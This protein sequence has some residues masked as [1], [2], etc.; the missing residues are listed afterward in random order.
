MWF[1]MVFLVM[2]SEL[3]IF[4]LE[5]LLVISCRILVLWFV[6]GL[7]WFRLMNLLCMCF[8]LDSRCWVMVGWISELLLVMVW[9]VLISC[10]RVMFLSRQFLVLVFN[11]V[12]ISWLLL[13]VVRM[14]VGGNWFNCDS[15]CSV[16]SLDII[17][18]CMF[19]SIMLG[20]ICGIM[21]IVWCL[22]VVLVIILMLLLS[23]SSE[24]IFC[25]IR[26]WLLIRQM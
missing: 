2:F 26:V 14:M 1:L 6:N 23:V 19:M 15:I 25:C 24:W 11:L 13:N 5:N 20:C 12:S 16:F 7:G 3:V 21:F 9:I 4:L 22:L 18:M 8:S 10:F 17:G